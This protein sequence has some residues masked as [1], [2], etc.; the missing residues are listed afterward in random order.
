MIG[1]E[2]SD[3]VAKVLAGSNLERIDVGN[4]RCVLV[5]WAVAAF[6]ERPGEEVR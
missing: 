3:Y 5:A 6:P 4:R 2:D 1:R